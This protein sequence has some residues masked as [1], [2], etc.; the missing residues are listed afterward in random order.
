MP[1][2]KPMYDQHVRISGLQSQDSVS[3]GFITYPSCNI[4]G[5][6]YLGEYLYDKYN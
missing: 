1:I 6:N 3:K 5:K 2:P 4:C